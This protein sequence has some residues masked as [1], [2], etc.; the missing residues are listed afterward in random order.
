MQINT[1]HYKKK[2]LAQVEAVFY[3]VIGRILYFTFMVT[4]KNI[5]EMV[6]E[7]CSRAVKK[8]SFFSILPSHPPGHK[9]FISLSLKPAWY[10]LYIRG[11]PGLYKSCLFTPHPK[12]SSPHARGIQLYDGFK[13]SLYTTFE[14]SLFSLYSIYTA[15]TTAVICVIKSLH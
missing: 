3:S 9:K 7:F 1:A 2:Y 6:G 12:L 13:R 15:R 11:G 14:M 10:I 5:A 8:L 4:L